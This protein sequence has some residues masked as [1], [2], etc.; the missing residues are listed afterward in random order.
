M[1]L[2]YF[3]TISLGIF[4]SFLFCLLIS[5]IDFYLLLIPTFFTP[6]FVG[7]T[8]GIIY[9]VVFVTTMG[10][11]TKSYFLE[12]WNKKIFYKSIIIPLMFFLVHVSYI[13]TTYTTLYRNDVN[14]QKSGIYIAKTLSSFSG[15][16]EELEE[17]IKPFFA[18]VIKH[19]GLNPDEFELAIKLPNNTSQYGQNFII[20]VRNNTDISY[21]PYITL[22]PVNKKQEWIFFYVFTN[23]NYEGENN[24]NLSNKNI[25]F[26]TPYITEPLVYK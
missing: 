16:R 9:A 1:K 20:E 26:L 18:D 15:T 24:T 10:N 12:N 13:T 17:M 7:V 19:Q 8:V 3:K 25:E 4:I 11:Y 2:I 14:I 22:S 6:K 5:Y 23:R 21:Y